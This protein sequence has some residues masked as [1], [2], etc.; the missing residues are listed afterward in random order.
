MEK[1]CIFHGNLKSVL[2]CFGMLP[3][4][5]SDNPA[6]LTETPSQSDSA[7]WEK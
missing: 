6:A 3:L 5:K 1:V 2:V 4:E 7:T